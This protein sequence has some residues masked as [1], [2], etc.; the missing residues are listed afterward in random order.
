M[1]SGINTRKEGVRAHELHHGAK[2]WRHDADSMAERHSDLIAA[3]GLT[4]DCCRY[5]TRWLLENRATIL[6]LS[7]SILPLL[8][9]TDL[10]HVLCHIE[11]GTLALAHV[12]E[13][14]ILGCLSVWW[15][16]V[17]VPTTWGVYK[18]GSLRHDGVR[19][20]ALK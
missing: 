4:R 15:S 6:I 17:G 5:V 7:L 8:G 12:L 14:S 10:T 20:G 19:Y 13:G 16:R 2:L 18:L 11:S 9:A 3:S 1:C